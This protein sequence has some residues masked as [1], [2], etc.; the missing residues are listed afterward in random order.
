MKHLVITFLSQ[1]ATAKLHEKVDSKYKDLLAHYKGGVAYLFL[2]LKITFF[3][4]H[5][6]I[7]VMRKYLKLLE[8]MGLL[9]SIVRM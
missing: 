3:I 2:Q 4:S 1:T 8:D 5:D 9:E 7:N 6:T